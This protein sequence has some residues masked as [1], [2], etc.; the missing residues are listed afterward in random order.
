MKDRLFDEKIKLFIES[1][2]NEKLEEFTWVLDEDNKVFDLQKLSN[3][4]K[5]SIPTVYSG[6]I[7]NADLFICLYNPG[8]DFTKEE[9]KEMPSIEEYLEKDRVFQ[10]LETIE[11]YINDCIYSNDNILYKEMKNLKKIYK[12]SSQ[13]KELK[14]D[15]ELKQNCYYLYTYFYCIFKGKT[16]REKIGDAFNKD[17]SFFKDLKI[18]NLE[19]IPYRSLSK[20][21]LQYNE[22][23]SIADLQ[24]VTETVGIIQKR[25]KNYES[26]NKQSTEPMFIFRNYSDWKSAFLSEKLLSSEEKLLKQE[27]KRLLLEK[28]LLSM[29]RY[30]YEFTTNSIVDEK[31]IAKVLSA[32]DKNKIRSV[33]K[34]EK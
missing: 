34:D 23:K 13:I 10:N 16:K 31:Y 11:N 33:F 15:I 17:L 20:N 8:I 21:E 3:S 30:F 29:E 7:D 22:K 19:L 1:V 4:T 2:K 24:I 6:N 18:C 28:K 25:I 12:S 9:L 14:N 27:E 5:Y 26:N 32:E